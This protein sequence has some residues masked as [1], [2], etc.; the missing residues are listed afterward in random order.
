MNSL[1]SCLVASVLI[2]AGGDSR[3]MLNRPNSWYLWALL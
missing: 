3:F 2:I 1:G